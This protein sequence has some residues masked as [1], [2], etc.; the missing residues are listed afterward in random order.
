MLLEDMLKRFAL[1]NIVVPFLPT[2]SLQ[3]S[4]YMIL[5]VKVVP[6]GMLRFYASFSACLSILRAQYRTLIAGHCC[7]VLT[8]HLLTSLSLVF[9]VYGQYFKA[10]MLQGTLE[11]P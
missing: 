8:F 11:T 1:L 6:D 9:S 3:S 2:I 10:A 4:I 5:I 7:A